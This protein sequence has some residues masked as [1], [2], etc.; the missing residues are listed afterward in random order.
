[1]ANLN[2]DQYMNVPKKPKK[3]KNS[4]ILSKNLLFRNSPKKTNLKSKKG[5]TPKYSQN[6]LPFQNWPSK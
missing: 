1:M 6:F 3:E 4:E 5:K 2:R